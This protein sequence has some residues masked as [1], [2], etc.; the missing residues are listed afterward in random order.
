MSKFNFAPRAVSADKV[1]ERGFRTVIE[2]A[3]DGMSSVTYLFEDI[4]YT[5][6]GEVLSHKQTRSHVVNAPMTDDEK[7]ERQQIFDFKGQPTGEVMT[8]QDIYLRVKQLL[9]S[10]LI[11]DLTKNELIEI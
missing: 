1:R 3:I 11:N 8:K 2:D 4:E 7:N 6:D 10:V 5:S 9:N